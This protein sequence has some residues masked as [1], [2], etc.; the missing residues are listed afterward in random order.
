VGSTFTVTV[1]VSPRAA[2]ANTTATACSGSSFSVTPTNG[3]DIVPLG[4]TYAWSSLPVVTGGLTGGATATGQSSISGTL[5]NPT[6]TPQTATYT[7]T[8]T[9][10]LCNGP[11]FTVVATINPKP[12]IANK[13]AT[14]CSGDAFTITPN[15]SGSEIVP[16]STTYTW[17]ISTNTNITGQSAQ[18]SAQSSIGQ[19]LNNLTNS[20]QTITYTVTPT[21]GAAGNCVGSTFTVVVTVSPKPRIANK[22]ATTCSG[23]AFTVTPTNGTDIVPSGIRYAW[24]APTVTGGLTGGVSA[25]G[26][27]TITGTLT[28]PTNTQQ[29]ATYTVTPTSGSCVGPTFTVVVTLNPKPVIANKT[30]VACSG[31]PFSVIPVN[32]SDIVPAGTTYTWLTPTVTGLMTGGAGGTAQTSVFGTLTNSTTTTQTATYTVTP[33]I[34][35][36]SGSTFTVVATINP[37]PTVSTPTSQVL[38]NGSS[39]TAVTFSGTVAGTTYFWTNNNTAIG[40]AANGNGNISSFTA[41]NSTNA[42]IVATITVTPI[43]SNGGQSCS[44]TPKTFTITVNP[45]PTVAD[46]TNIAFCRGSSSSIITLSGSLVSGTTY[47]WSNSNTAI[48][49]AGSGSGNIASFVTTNTTNAAI[50]GLITV[51]PKYTNGGITCSGTAKTFTITI[52][53]VPT[54]TKPTNQ[55]ICVGAGTSTV[56]FG[57]SLVTNTVYNWTNNNTAI[58]LAASGTGNI[59]S[60]TATNNTNAPITATITVTPSFTNAGSTCAGPSQTF[61]ITVNPKPAIPDQTVTTCTGSTFSF[62]AANSG[63][64]IVPSSTTYTWTIFTNNP[65]L[66]GQTASASAQSTISQTLTSS[67][68]SNQDIV[69]EV[70]PRTGSCVAIHLN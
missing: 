36:C 1:T 5:T 50:S 47:D 15:N 7:V 2:I 48:G 8:P 29:T 23:V 26:Q 40:L 52:N 14:I 17:T 63:S 4:T 31:A 62:A 13:T 61:S 19:T 30:A 41:T 45:T 10:G 56:T 69:Y 65:N 21:S 28:N 16:A 67:V 25:T 22:T 46:Q 39:S 53:P 9:S 57:G 37:T 59:S 54:V 64:T 6:N 18:S 49:L 24:S 27:T 51:T 42:P 55:T 35:S 20:A 43:Y 33:T 38:C 34:G 12:A 68:S 11:T 32:G 66:T 60:F 44:G 58:G 3:T 70:T